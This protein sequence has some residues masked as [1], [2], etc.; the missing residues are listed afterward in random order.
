MVPHNLHY[1]TPP[2]PASTCVTDDS[3]GSISPS[4]AAAAATLFKGLVRAAREESTGPLFGL[5]PLII[6]GTR[7]G[8]V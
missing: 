1:A 5:P 2:P 8:L 3:S 6:P 4:V 7:P